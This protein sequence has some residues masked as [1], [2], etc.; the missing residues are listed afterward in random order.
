M[1]TSKDSSSLAPSKKADNSYSVVLSEIWFCFSVYNR[2]ARYK[3]RYKLQFYSFLFLERKRNGCEWK[4]AALHIDVLFEDPHCSDLKTERSVEYVRASTLLVKSTFSVLEMGLKNG[5]VEI[6]HWRYLVLPMKWTALEFRE[7]MQKWS[8]L[9]KILFFATSIRTPSMCLGLIMNSNCNKYRNI[10]SFFWVFYITK[11]SSKWLKTEL[12]FNQQVW[13]PGEIS[14]RKDL[15][16]FEDRKYYSETLLKQAYSAWS[17]TKTFWMAH[18]YGF[19]EV[20]RVCGCPTEEESENHFI[21]RRRKGVVIVD[22]C[23]W[24]CHEYNI[25]CWR[26]KLRRVRWASM[27]SFGLLCL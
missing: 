13:F 21:S 5:R 4:W 12:I 3:R 10:S 2:L 17:I 6:K 15:R 20:S 8:S 25:C 23:F 22:S 1:S 26:H 27:A 7:V 11:T 16:N 19:F 14:K 24:E 9:S 18:G